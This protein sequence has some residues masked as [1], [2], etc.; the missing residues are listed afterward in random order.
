MAKHHGLKHGKD[1]GKGKKGFVVGPGAEG[2]EMKAPK[3]MHKG[4]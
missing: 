2:K 3:H 4:K 1:G